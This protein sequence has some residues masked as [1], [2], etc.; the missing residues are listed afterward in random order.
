MKL[1]YVCSPYR[2]ETKKAVKRNVKRAR[3]YCRLVCQQGGIPFA[4]HLLFTQFLRDDNSRHRRL[5]F[6]M[7]FEMLRHCDELWVFGKPSA[8]M[9]G[10]I[11]YAMKYGIPIRWLDSEGRSSIHE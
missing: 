8:G 3:Y 7:G 6:R 11:A 9:A 2:G 5:G 4:P 1:V 10:E